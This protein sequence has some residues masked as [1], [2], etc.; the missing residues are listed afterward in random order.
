LGVTIKN[1]ELDMECVLS[2]EKYMLHCGS[3]K[4]F[5]DWVDV[6]KY[7]I[8]LAD[9]ALNLYPIY[10]TKPFWSSRI[11]LCG[12]SVVGY[13]LPSHIKQPVDS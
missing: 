10:E 5:W 11:N 13:E 6:G 1:I 4:G 12:D 9:P 7:M 8:V 2:W 3:S